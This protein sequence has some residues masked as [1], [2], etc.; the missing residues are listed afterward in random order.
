MPAPAMQ[1]FVGTIAGD[2]HSD[3]LVIQTGNW[4]FTLLGSSRFGHWL[5]APAPTAGPTVHTYVP[6]AIPAGAQL[7]F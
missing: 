6:F 7:Q 5:L 4:L 1:V 2:P 3:V